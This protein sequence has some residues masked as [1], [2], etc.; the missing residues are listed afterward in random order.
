MIVCANCG[1]EM[2]KE[3]ENDANFYVCDECESEASDELNREVAIGSFLM[4]E[5]VRHLHRM[6]AGATEDNVIVDDCEYNIAIKFV[7]RIKNK[8]G[9]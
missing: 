1:K 5:V 3:K 8:E 7:K 4:N 6:G 2:P 9:K